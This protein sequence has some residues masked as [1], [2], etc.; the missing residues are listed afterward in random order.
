MKSRRDKIGFGY[1]NGQA[2]QFHILDAANYVALPFGAAV[3]PKS[4][5]KVQ[6]QSSGSSHG[7][8]ENPPTQSY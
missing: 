3:A 1:A 5:P 8:G 4:K 2:L 7:K 6:P